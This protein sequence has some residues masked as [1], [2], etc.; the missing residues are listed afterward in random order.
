MVNRSIIFF[1][2]T[3]IAFCGYITMGTN[4]LSGATV[5]TNLLTVL[6]NG[7]KSS[8]GFGVEAQ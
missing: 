4:E 6:P 7:K 2:V 1:L 8:H 3:A 5:I